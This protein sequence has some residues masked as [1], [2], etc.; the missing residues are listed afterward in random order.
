[1][2]FGLA[3]R[4]SSDDVQVTQSGAIMGTPAYMS[5]E[6]VEGDQ[7]K[8]GPQ[9]DIYALGI[10]MY[11]LITGEMPY[12]GSLMSILQQ[13][14]LNNPEKPS[15][16][17]TDLDPRMEQICLKMMAGDLSTRY[18]SMDEVAADLQELAR[19][20]RKEFKQRASSGKS[21]Q[22]NSIATVTEESDPATISIET[23]SITEQR[24]EKRAASKSKRKTSSR[25]SSSGGNKKLL[26]S[27]G[28]IGFL[29][30]G[31]VFFV[32]VGKYDVQIT[33]DDPGITLSVDGD[34][35]NIKDG[36][37][38]YQLS[39]GPHKLQLQKDGLKTLVEEFTVTKDGK[40]ALTAKVMN[41]KLGAIFNSAKPSVS[42]SFDDGETTNADIASVVPT[43]GD[44]PTM[45]MSPN[46]RSEGDAASDPQVIESVAYPGKF[47]L[48][49]P[50][51]GE[52]YVE[53]PTLDSALMGE[54]LREKKLNLTIEF[55]L[56]RD[57]KQISPHDHYAGWSSSYLFVRSAAGSA[58]VEG[59]EWGGRGAP[60]I[61]F[62]DT[63]APTRTLKNEAVWTHVAAVLINPTEY[64]LFID[65][66]LVDTKAAEWGWPGSDDPFRLM[67]QAAGMMGETRVSTTARYDKD[68][69]PEFGFKPD[70]HTLALYHFDEGTGDVL[71][72][73]SGNGHDGKIT[74]AMWIKTGA[75][76]APPLS[77]PVP[78]QAGE[79]S[80]VLSFP[81][82]VENFVDVPTLI[83][84]DFDRGPC[85]IETWYRLDPGASEMQFVVG[86]WRER[87]LLIGDFNGSYEKHCAFGRWH[88]T[89]WDD[90]TKTRSD[91]STWTH[92]ALVRDETRNCRLYVNGRYV[93]E[94]KVEQC[95]AP[96]R[97]GIMFAGEISETRV[98]SVARYTGDFAPANRFEP[99]QHTLALYHFDE[100]TGDVL[101]DSSGNG[102]HG[103]IVGAKWL[104]LDDHSA[105][106]AAPALSDSP[107][108]E[109][110]ESDTSASLYFAN[111]EDEVVIPT[112]SDETDPLT[113]ELW[114]QLAS[115]DYIAHSQVLGFAHDMS[116]V[117]NANGVL[118]F[119]MA[120]TGSEDG[121]LQGTDNRGVNQPIHIAGVRDPELNEIRL[122]HDGKLIQTSPGEIQRGTGNLQIASKEYQWIGNEDHQFNG[123]IDE[124]RI[125]RSVRYREDF[126]PQRRFDQD[127]E[128]TALYHFEEGTGDILKDSSGN[129]HHGKIIG[130][131]W[132]SDRVLK[133]R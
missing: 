44:G 37:D 47:A 123:W 65:G 97:I 118:D 129:G 8:I 80:Y 92:A 9:A 109:R 15:N 30:M 100:G 121:P 40:T 52:N 96:F 35:L 1:M 5:P 28:V 104:Q 117:T 102:H 54:L 32:R 51:R 24:R 6:Q 49:F 58:Y 75:M 83:G 112:L 84:K 17:R 95:P 27:A 88:G 42:D 71:K 119:Q 90:S 56:K 68:F 116:I 10:I 94:S 106:F 73:S 74:G 89:I 45:E 101:K 43:T 2:D 48:A 78:S 115:N 125:S 120:E 59:G 133:S 53:M 13:I 50:E 20:P 72:D 132:M 34:V 22:Q 12:K 124:V 16:L 57:E 85:T 114:L 76:P 128:T 19:A 18:Q 7:D 105:E 61:G 11:E 55:W 110:G 127:A 3:R 14:A 91:P 31:I 108:N 126:T 86:L 66:K 111:V 23:H 4:S 39:A 64:R 79:R 113:I 130:A 21:I 99:D 29:L 26:I 107:A 70:E 122:Y 98:S 103:K 33:I 38:V 41:G 67:A 82:G 81:G 93:A 69:T 131:K 25:F 63:A 62:Y 46:K 77:E 36:Q 87:T 60:P